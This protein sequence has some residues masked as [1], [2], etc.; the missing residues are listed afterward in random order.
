MPIH[1][2]IG[3]FGVLL[4][5]ADI[6]RFENFALRGILNEWPQCQLRI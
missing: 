6:N 1:P 2:V 3:A 4:D 5:W